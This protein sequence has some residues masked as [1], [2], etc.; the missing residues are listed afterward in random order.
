MVICLGSAFFAR[1]RAKSKGVDGLMG[2]AGYADGTDHWIEPMKAARE[3][4]PRPVLLIGLNEPY[5]KLAE[6]N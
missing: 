6:I 3:M 5:Y 4:D 1:H 2:L